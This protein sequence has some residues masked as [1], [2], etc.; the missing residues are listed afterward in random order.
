MLQAGENPR[1]LPKIGDNSRKRKRTFFWELTGIFGCV[2][3][4]FAGI[5]GFGAK[6]PAKK[7][8]P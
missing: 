8:L 5:F 1:Q 7:Y 6:G 2:F 3:L 4:D